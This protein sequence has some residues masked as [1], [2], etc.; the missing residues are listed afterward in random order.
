MLEVFWKLLGIT[1]TGESEG[2]R[3]SDDIEGALS[4]FKTNLMQRVTDG[5]FTKEQCKKIIEYSRKGYF[6]HF[7]LFDYV[8]N[9]KQLS[10]V[11]RVTLF[12]ELPMTAGP[13][14]EAMD[15]QPPAEEEEQEEVKSPDEEAAAEGEGAEEAD[16]APNE[17]EESEEGDSGDEDP[18]AGLDERLE[19]LDEGAKMVITAKLNEF[20]TKIK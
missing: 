2:S 6:R 12:Q 11:K 5:T 10:D 1:N 18:L 20:H 4:I 14:N 16:K 19:K 17:G 7:R 15:I 3:A 8:L 13:L 9:N